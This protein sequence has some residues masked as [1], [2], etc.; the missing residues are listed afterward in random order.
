[1]VRGW[2]GALALAA[3]AL[4]LGTAHRAK[5]AAPGRRPSGPRP[6]QLS[7]AMEKACMTKS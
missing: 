2:M 4:S 3:L 5:E 7:P 1:M 6:P